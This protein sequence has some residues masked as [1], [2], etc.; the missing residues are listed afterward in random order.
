MDVGVVTLILILFS[1]GVIS[2]VDEQFINP[3]KK[4]EVSKEYFI[5]H[6]D[7]S[8]IKKVYTS[9]WSLDLTFNNL[10]KNHEEYFFN[11]LHY[12][13]SKDS[14][15][16]IIEDAVFYKNNKKVMETKRKYNISH[17]FSINNKIY[18][19]NDCALH[20]KKYLIHLDSVDRIILIGRKLR[21]KKIKNR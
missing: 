3:P 7:T 8:H 14:D 18:L 10:I 13:G 11:E 17:L 19:I 5:Q 15:L 4:L 6:T 2:V 20:Q 1:L 9:H 12:Y 16:I 21:I